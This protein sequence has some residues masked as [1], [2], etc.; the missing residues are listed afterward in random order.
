MNT[1]MQAVFRPSEELRRILIVEDEIVNQ[2]ILSRYLEGTYTV[3]VAS[4]GSQAM[5]AIHTQ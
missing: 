3:I 1:Q 2:K 5:E 4:D